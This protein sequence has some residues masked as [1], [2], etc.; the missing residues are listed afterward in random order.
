MNSTRL[1]YT[2]RCS[3]SERCGARSYSDKPITSQI[4]RRSQ[5][6]TAKSTQSGPIRTQR[7]FKPTNPDEGK[8]TDENAQNRSSTRRDD[9]RW[10]IWTHQETDQSQSTQDPNGPMRSRE[11]FERTNRPLRLRPLHST[12]QCMFF[13]STNVK[14]RV[15]LNYFCNVF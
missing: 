13:A 6:C 9:W 1:F 7:I 5:D 15:T 8:R 12:F 11:W 14:S 4:E 2:S 3:K 10:P